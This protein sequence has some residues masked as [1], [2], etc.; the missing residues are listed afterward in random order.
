[1]LL[2]SLFSGF[3]LRPN[4]LP[5]RSFF[6]CVASFYSEPFRS[7]LLLLFLVATSTFRLRPL[8]AELPKKVS[9]EVLNSGSIYTSISWKFST[10]PPV[11]LPFS[12]QLSVSFPLAAPLECFT[13]SQR[14]RAN[15]QLQRRTRRETLRRPA[16]LLSEICVKCCRSQT[17]RR[18]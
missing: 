8:P 3:T 12:S 2:S 7:E 15:Q 1:M 6:L 4:V 11:R 5:R 13:Q 16:R 18:L 17:L 9:G 14:R 10:L